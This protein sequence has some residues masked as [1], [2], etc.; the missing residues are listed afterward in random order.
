M[1]FENLINYLTISKSEERSRAIV[2]KLCHLMIFISAL[3]FA[4]ESNAQISGFVFRDFNGDGARQ[5][6]QGAPLTTSTSTHSAGFVEPLVAG[7]IVTAYNSNDVI[8]ASYTTSSPSP[9]TATP[10][11]TANYTIP[12]TGSAYTGTKGNNTGFVANDVAVRLEFTIP[13]SVTCLISGVYDFTSKAGKVYGTSVRFIAASGSSGTARPNI[14]FALNNPNDYVAGA[15]PETSTYL[16]QAVQFNGD[17]LGGGTTEDENALVKFPYSRNGTTALSAAEKLASASQIGSVY[18]VAYSKYA[19]KIFTSAFMKRHAGFGPANGVEKNKPGAIYIVDPSLSSTTGTKAASY[20]LSLDALGYATHNTLVG[21]PAY[22][23]TSSYSIV[24]SGS[25]DTRTETITYISTGE[26]VIGANSGTGSR[27]LGADNVT[28]SNDPA[29]FGQ[30]GKVS[31]GAIE[32]SD[33]GKYLFVVNLY[34]RKV[35]QLQLNSVTAPTSATYVNSWSLPNPPARALSGYSGAAATYVTTPQRLDMNDFYDGDRGLQR[36]FALKYRNGKLYV[37]SVTTGEVAGAESITDNNT[38]TVEFTDLWAYVWELTPSSGFTN[39]T[40]VLQFPLNYNKGTNGDGYNETWKPWTNTFPTANVNAGID[41]WNVAQAMLTGI[42][43]DVD[44][45]MILALRDLSGDKGGYQNRMLTGTTVSRTSMAFGDQL[46]AH[47]N[48]TNCK[49]ELEYAGEEGPNSFK[50]ASLG[51]TN[52][53]GP[54]GGEFYYTDGIERYN[55]T[56]S[57]VAYHLNTAMGGLALL[58]GM[59]EVTA[60][61]MDPLA[62]WSGGVSWSRSFNGLNT[63]D[64][65]LYAGQAVGDIGKANGLGDIELLFENPPIEIGNRVWKDTDGDGIQ[66]ADEAGIAGVLLEL[67]NSGGTVIAT[68]TT[69]TDGSWYF[70]S[71]TGTD[72]TGIKYSVALTPDTDYKVRL[73]S[74]GTGNDWDATANSNAGGP[75]TGGALVGLRLTRTD[76]IGNGEADFSDSD[77]SMVSSVPSISLTTGGYGENNH[78]YDIGFAENV[79]LGNKVWKDTDNDGIIDASEPVFTGVTVNLYEDLDDNGTPDGA[80]IATTTTNGTTGL[81]L[82]NN[83]LPGTYIVGVVTPTGF[84]SSS[85]NA[86]D[87]DTDTDDNDD[88]GVVTSGTETRSNPITLV[89]GGEPT[90]DNTPD[91]NPAGAIANN[92]SNLTVDFG[93]VELMN[94]GNKVWKDVNNNG[95]I[96]GGEAVFGNVTVNLYKDAN[97][98]GTPEG[99]IFATTT[100]DPTTGL[101]L[102]NNLLPGTYIVGVVTPT[103]FVSSSVDAGDPDTDTDDND[104]NGVVTSGTE[105]RS[106]PI[107]LVP[108][109][110]PTGDNTPDNNPAGVIANNSSNLTVDFGFVELLNLGN[111]VWKDVN[112]NGIIDNSEPVFGN[113]T[114]NLYKDANDDGTPDGA[115]FATTTTDPTTGLYLFNNLL[116]GT[117]IVGVVTPTG[118]VSSSV[119]AGDPDTDTDDNDDN[120]VVASG[121]ETRSNPITLVPGGEPTGDNTPDNNPAGVIAN[122]SSNLT[123]DFGFVELLNLGNKVWK[124]VNNNGIIDNS[125]PVFGNVTVNLYKDANDDGTPDGAVFATTTTD[126]TTGLYLFNN[127]LPGTYIVGVVT[128]TGFVSSSV[129]AGDP[130]TDTDDTDDNGVVTSGTE[131]RSNP[132][133]LVPGGEP[134]GENPNNNPASVIADNSSNLTVDFGFVELVNLGNKVW[135]DTNKDGI[136]GAAEP[137]LAGVTVNLYADVDKNGTVDGAGNGT[138]VATTTTD[139]NG[140]YL[141]NSLLPGNYMVAVVTPTGLTSSAVNAGDPDTDLD[142]NDDN[143]VTTV[144]TETRSDMITLAPGDEPT[145]ED[146]SNNPAG[147]IANNS[148]NLTVDFG[149]FDPTSLPVNLINFDGKADE[150]NRVRLAW[151]TAQEANSSHFEVQRSKDGTTWNGIGTVSAL[152]ESKIA[153]SYTFLDLNPLSGDNLYRLRMVDQDATFAFSRI[154]NVKLETAFSLNLFPNPASD[155]LKIEASNGTVVQKVQIYSLLGKLVKE[156][157]SPKQGE[158]NVQSLAAGAY[159][160]RITTADGSVEMRKV[161]ITR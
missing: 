13:T 112:N 28:P 102:F 24:T 44:G 75:R 157:A 47:K 106:N 127:L 35:Y 10:S 131:T 51:P 128:P 2:P 66:G 26:G 135:K 160:V 81:Y 30:V 144:G 53:Q 61:F 60:T 143:G 25:A 55:G 67:V 130:D 49:F 126:P 79:N 85:V 1:K 156:V 96:D 122:N 11:T 57:G 17:P 36:P 40:P 141:F 132:I 120:G 161:I 74:S 91:N 46:R 78:T 158:I 86:D 71:D 9:T 27:L 21:A 37:G 104:D 100:T 65:Q 97:D 107:T 14:H 121:T 43:F 41:G 92:S 154:I 123:V 110:E 72:A 134:T 137:V 48:T 31:L 12:N 101:Y 69:D 73:A 19:K 54:G 94:L 103:G 151:S 115:V 114:V 23:S 32:M 139:D 22:G 63:R 119:D 16:F 146:P 38:G 83:L 6:N 125:E 8:L 89:P 99:G 136:I 111:K 59:E 88:N 113:V 116:P 52:G 159:T 109:G 87:P 4:S 84:V 68:V 45:S 15:T 18:G 142:D 124:D 80:A 34:D 82:F 39:T 90:G 155:K 118:F 98:D 42:E 133:T 150:A 105:T 140:L 152:G 76:K 33:D 138:I 95:I 117:Y 153:H 20:F 93:F 147:V 149:F 50:P 145:G 108:G 58:P 3:L 70:S 62:I 5:T 77:A 129:N 7:V 29:A 64:Y 148:S 56:A